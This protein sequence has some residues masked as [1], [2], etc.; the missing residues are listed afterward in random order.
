MTYQRVREP[1][2]DDLPL[3]V[4]LGLVAAALV[5]VLFLAYETSAAV[6]GEDVS[7]EAGC[8]E[9]LQEYVRAAVPD[10]TPPGA[11]ERSGWS[12]DV[13]GRWGVR[14]PRVVDTRTRRCD[15]EAGPR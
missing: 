9:C 5:I 15:V 14:R 1:Q 2:H 8:P 7:H 4:I 10:P 11:Y 12:G 6:R 3:V 13:L